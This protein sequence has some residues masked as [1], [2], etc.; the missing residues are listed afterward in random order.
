MLLHTCTPELVLTPA[1]WVAWLQK[2]P[3][4]AVVL[5]ST[6][7]ESI[8]DRKV[9]MRATMSDGQG[10]VYASGRA[11]FVAPRLVKLAGTWVTKQPQQQQQQ[12]QQVQ[13]QR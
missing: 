6:E 12:Q 3:A 4:G 5:C 13:P 10:N 7:V 9:W 11:L 2:V 1:L 8:K